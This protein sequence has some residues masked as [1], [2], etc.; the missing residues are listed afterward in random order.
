MMNA[1]FCSVAYVRSV[2]IAQEC[3][4]SSG[5]SLIYLFDSDTDLQI[6]RS[7]ECN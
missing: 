7:T 1:T 3:C 5:C 6:G 2:L 4:V